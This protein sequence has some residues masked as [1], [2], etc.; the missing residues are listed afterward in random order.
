MLVEQYCAEGDASAS[1]K[2][3]LRELVAQAVE[4]AA[5]NAVVVARRYPKASARYGIG[6]IQRVIREFLD[7]GAPLPIC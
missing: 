1:L 6:D 4:A 2:R 3:E 5:D 7:Q